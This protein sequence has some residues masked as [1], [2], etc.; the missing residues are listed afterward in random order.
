[1]KRFVRVLVI[2]CISLLLP[3]PSV[4]G[5]ELIRLSDE[6][7]AE[8]IDDGI[9][10]VTHSFP[11]PANAM[12][13]KLSDE[14]FLLVDTP[15]ENGATETLVEWAKNELGCKNMTVINTHFHRDNLGGNGYLLGEEIPVYGSDFTVELLRERSDPKAI[16]RWL[17]KPEYK[18]YREVFETAELVPPDHVFPIDEGLILNIGD[19]VVEIYYPG[20]AHAPD[21]IVVYLKNRKILFGGCMI[22]SLASTKLGNLG[23][24][25]VEEWPTSARTV[26]ERYGDARVVIPGHG[27]WGDMSLVDHTIELVTSYKQE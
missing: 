1:M 8:E 11:W 3:Q 21:N 5:E 20:P 17:E 26:K 25:N 13:A 19:E 16:L 24:A 9:Y 15:W 10:F 12:L 2:A 27:S 7:T 23:D 6:L 4:A 22:R 18:R 14:D